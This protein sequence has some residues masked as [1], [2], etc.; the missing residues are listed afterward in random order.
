MLL[1]IIT[2]IT[3]IKASV[4]RVFGWSFVCLNDSRA[5]E[6]TAPFFVRGASYLMKHYTKTKLSPDSFCWEYLGNTQSNSLLKWKKQTKIIMMKGT[7]DS[8]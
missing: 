5:S 2:V 4:T 1:L 6:H 7:L 8:K 3:E